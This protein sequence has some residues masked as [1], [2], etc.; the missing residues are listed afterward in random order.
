MFVSAFHDA[1]NFVDED[2]L[3]GVDPELESACLQQDTILH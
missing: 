2:D 3:I 1:V